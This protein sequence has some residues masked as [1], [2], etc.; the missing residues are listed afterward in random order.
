MKIISPA[1][2][3]LHFCAY[4]AEF[5]GLACVCCQYQHSTINMSWKEKVTESPFLKGKESVEFFP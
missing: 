3:E 1:K 2:E 4:P 5:G